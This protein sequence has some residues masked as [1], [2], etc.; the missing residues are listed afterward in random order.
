MAKE[1]DKFFKYLKTERDFSYYT[2]K[3]YKE[4][5]TI[6]LRF[7]ENKDL[8]E[9]T[10]LDIRRFLAYLR[11]KGD[12]KRTISRRLSCLRSFFK[13][14]LREGSIKKNPTL[15]ISGV[16][17]DKPLPNFLS[18]QDVG[19]LLDREKKDDYISSRDMAILETFYST[20]IRVSELVNLN[21]LD[22]DYISGVVKVYGKGKKERIVPIGD[23]ALKSIK[24]YL[25]KRLVLGYANKGGLFLN[26]RGYRI[27]ERSV[28]RIIKKYALKA[29]INMDISPHTLRHT[30]ATH[31]LDRGADLRSVQELLG[32]ASLST[33]QI[34]THLTLEGLKRIYEKAHPRA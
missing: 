22:I 25:D 21:I 24:L 15:A 16:K 5:L 26:A 10:H 32:H 4:D 2:L 30:F 8:K 12:S 3:S 20:G 28:G 23:K 9:V 31:L 34:Y 7:L 29:G 11:T 19:S 6:F 14:L 1:E 33:T 18:Y 27:T 17:L 13:F